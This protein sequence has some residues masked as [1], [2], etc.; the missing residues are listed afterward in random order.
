MSMS[1]MVGT[2]LLVKAGLRV[3]FQTPICAR[4]LEVYPP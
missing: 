2:P 1:L 3:G 4:V